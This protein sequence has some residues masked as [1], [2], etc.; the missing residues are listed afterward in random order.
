MSD[1]GDRRRLNRADRALLAVDRALRAMGGAGFDTQTFV[2]L[3]GRADVPRLRAA[4]GRLGRRRPETTARLAEDDAGGPCWRFRPDDRGAALHETDLGSE[5]PA[6][7]LGHAG[8][9]LAA[10]SDPAQVDPIRFHLLHRPGGRDVF[11][12]Q[13][14]HTLMG[15]NDA[16]PLLRLIDRLAAGEDAEAGAAGCQGDPV[17]AYLRR[18]PRG[19]RHAALRAADQWL[20]RLRRQ[21]GGAVQLGRD[22]PGPI[23]LRVITR[24]LGPEHAE[25]LDARVLRACGLPSPSLAILASAF[26]VLDRLTAGRGGAAGRAF[27]AGLGIAF[28]PDRSAE[29]LLQNVTSLLPVAA[30][31]EELGDRDGLLRALNGRM[32]EQL[33]ADMDL[34]MLG[35]AALLGRRPRQAR[36]VVEFALRH[37][38]SLWYAYFGSMDAAGRAFCGAPVREAFSAGPAW[39]PVG[40][41]LLVNRYGGRLFFQVTHVPASVPEALAD[42][43][44]DLLLR[45]LAE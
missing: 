7:V 13:Y 17:R 16:A 35:L 10:P 24:Q 42:E 1:G 41:T 45:D 26:R 25:A 19:R 22:S 31:P 44:L 40:L 3:D 39:P 28:R 30:R 20:R 32:R 27:S 23:R 5:A 36:W 43:F 21:Y 8:R 11:L 34:G 38:V 6:E 37:L 15:H 4:L 33:A 9:L 14:N 29:P 2:W 18:F 12:M